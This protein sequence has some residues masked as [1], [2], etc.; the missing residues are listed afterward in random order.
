M[1]YTF[2]HNHSYSHLIVFKEI[3]PIKDLTIFGDRELKYNIRRE[4]IKL[5]MNEYMKLYL[6]DKLSG[7]LDSKLITFNFLEL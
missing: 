1:K 5:D 2:C 6:K 7:R 3:E 4:I